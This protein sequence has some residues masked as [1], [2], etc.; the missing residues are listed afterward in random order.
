MFRQTGIVSAWLIAALSAE[1]TPASHPIVDLL[2][3]EDG[4]VDIDTNTV[5]RAI[6][7][8]TL[9]RKNA[10]FAGSEHWATLASLIETCKLNYVDLTPT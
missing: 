7:P 8:L 1:P 6:R 3:L 9:N 4:R 10:L 5:K 2:F